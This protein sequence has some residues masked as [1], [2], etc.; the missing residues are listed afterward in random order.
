MSMAFYSAVWVCSKYLRE[1]YSW[2]TEPVT[3]L[4][5]MVTV[6]NCRSHRCACTAPLP[7]ALT[8]SREKMTSSTPL[9]TRTG[10]ERRW[11][12]PFVA[13]YLRGHCRGL[14]EKGNFGIA[15]VHVQVVLLRPRA[16]FTQVVQHLTGGT[17]R[18]ME[19]SVAN[20]SVQTACNQHKRISYEFACKKERK[21][22][23][24]C[25]NWACGFWTRF[26]FPPGSTAR[27]D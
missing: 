19:D 11:P 26:S 7:E 14:R 22:L 6:S 17:M 1:F 16:P 3:G 4:S 24:S 5:L 8:R 2:S 13:P 18:I 9:R 27:S 12:M 20:G 10:A 25:V 21:A 15:L 23:V